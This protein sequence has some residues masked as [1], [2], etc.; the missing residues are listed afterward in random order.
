LAAPSEG[1]DIVSDY[2]GMRLTLGRHPLTLLRKK[3][4]RIRV[5]RAA[6]LS[7]LKSGA[8]VRV[9][10]IVTHRRRPETASGVIFLLL[11]DET[12]ISKVSYRTR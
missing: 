1:E 6:E 11:E 2:R 3:L 9:A 7:E 12:G 5:I 4:D 8:N 10:G